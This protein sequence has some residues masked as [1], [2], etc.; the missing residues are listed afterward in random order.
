ML[1]MFVTVCVYC[2]RFSPLQFPIETWSWSRELLRWVPRAF[3]SRS[4]VISIRTCAVARFPR[5]ATTNASITRI[6]IR[7]LLPTLCLV[8]AIDLFRFAK[9]ILL[10][11][12]L[13]TED[14]LDIS[15]VLSLVWVFPYPQLSGIC[16]Q[17]IISFNPKV[18]VL[19]V[20]SSSY[21]ISSQIPSLLPSR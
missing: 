4:R 15:A 5:G 13:N 11:P 12:T 18:S 6:A 9:I 19:S 2:S 7:Q 20:L 1:L 21:S 16:K 17:P 8:E 14:R 10:Y 3:A